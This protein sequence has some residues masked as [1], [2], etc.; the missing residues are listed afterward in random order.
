MMETQKNA[1]QDNELRH[2]QVENY[3]LK[4]KTMT[5]MFSSVWKMTVNSDY[6]AA[7]ASGLSLA[8]EKH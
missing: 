6:I 3:N 1:S 5:T 2:G 7:R 4:C 8:H